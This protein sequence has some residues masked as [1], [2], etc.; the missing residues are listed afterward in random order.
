MHYVGVD[1]GG[2]KTRGV[3][4]GDDGRVIREAE[5]GPANM[6][7]VGPERAWA[8]VADVI[9][10]LGS[11]PGAPM[12]LALAGAG[13]RTVRESWSQLLAGA[14]YRAYQVT[15]DFRAAW[16][17]LTH[18]DPGVVLIT[19]TGSVV[20]GENADGM[21]V[22]IGGY[23]P[24]L[25]D[26]G[27]ALWTAERALHAALAAMEGWG[28]A[29]RL[30]EWARAFG[31]TPAEILDTVYQEGYQATALAGAAAGVFALADAGDAVATRIR[32]AGARQL[33]GELQAA[34]RRLGATG[35]EL[36]GVAGGLATLWLPA[37]TLELRARGLPDPVV[38][39]DPPA[40]GAAW[41]ARRWSERG[42]GGHA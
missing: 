25:G 40:H 12:V 31:D 36:L 19:G 7:S 22:R 15:E 23:G 28:P 42:V 21:A 20:Y 9:R 14:G 3:V 24:R 35:R 5:G 16:A 33:A 8:N 18:G 34:Y 32:H 6:L 37:V 27:S 4:L 26:V 1:G 11:D 30:T 13:R 38:V 39:D 2:T 29:T 41:L 17:A 10:R